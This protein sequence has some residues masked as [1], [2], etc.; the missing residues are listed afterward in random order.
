MLFYLLVV[1]ITQAQLIIY[2]VQSKSCHYYLC[3]G[4]I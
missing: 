1:R 2:G 4:N 3:S